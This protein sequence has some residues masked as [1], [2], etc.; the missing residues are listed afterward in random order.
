MTPEEIRSILLTRK[1]PPIPAELE[2]VLARS[3]RPSESELIEAADAIVFALEK[4][5]KKFYPS[6]LPKKIFEIREKRKVATTILPRQVRPNQHSPRQH[7]EIHHATKTNERIAEKISNATKM[8]LATFPGAKVLSSSIPD[9]DRF[10]D[11]GLTAIREIL[12][13]IDEI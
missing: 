11:R 6:D 9:E 3:I 13:S 12:R 2:K 1:L 4:R 7:L 8:V 10:S 5:K